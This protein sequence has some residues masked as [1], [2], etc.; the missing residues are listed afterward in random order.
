[1][2]SAAFI[3]VAVQ[4]TRVTFQAAFWVTFQVIPCPTSVVKVAQKV[5]RNVQN[6]I[7]M[8]ASYSK[9]ISG[10]FLGRYWGPFLEPKNPIELPPWVPIFSRDGFSILAAASL[11]SFS[12]SS[13]FALTTWHHARAR[14]ATSCMLSSPLSLSLSHKPLCTGSCARGE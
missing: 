10:Q 2:P 4:Q 1:M 14:R 9:G 6:W 5:A 13:L 8:H 11:L 12:F 7:F 3:W